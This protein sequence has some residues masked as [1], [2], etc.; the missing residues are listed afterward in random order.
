[1]GDQREPSNNPDEAYL[2]EGKNESYIFG[3]IDILTEYNS[4]K[5][6]EFYFKRCFYGAG[7]SAVPPDE[8]AE[9]FVQFID[10]SVFRKT[11][12][13][14]ENVSHKKKWW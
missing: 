14:A 6:A 1:M 8:Y 3:I 12:S 10:K 5:A 4:K 7:I 9:R 2:Y 11:N 13:S